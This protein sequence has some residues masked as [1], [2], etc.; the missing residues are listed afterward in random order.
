MTSDRSADIINRL[1][2]VALR[3]NT[4]KSEAGAIAKAAE[5]MIACIQSGGTIIFCGNGGSAADC[6]HLA[7]ELMG[8]YLRERRPLP[9]LALTVDTSA[10]T[11]IGNDYGYE[12]VFSRQLR[13]IGKRGDLLVGISTSGNS[14]NVVQAFEVAKQSGISTVALTGQG[15]TLAAMA[16][17][18]IQVPS[19]ATNEIQEMHIVI[20]HM[21]CGYVEDAVC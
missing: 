11:A 10:L 21:L 7:A 2:G 19:M 1:D 3:F 9:A 8:R 18:A 15:G 16:D 5:M 4:L 13:G 6:Q 12:H 20:G 17:A 14:R